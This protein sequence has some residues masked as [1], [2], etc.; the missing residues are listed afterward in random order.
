MRLQPIVD[1]LDLYHNQDV[2]PR[3]IAISFKELAENHPEAEL[4]IVAMEKRGGNKFLLRAATTPDANHSELNAEY[5]ATYNQIKALTER[6]L[7][8]L[9]LLQKFLMI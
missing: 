6:E 9:D 5:F 4:E 2:D 3:A 7:Q 8:S 1:T